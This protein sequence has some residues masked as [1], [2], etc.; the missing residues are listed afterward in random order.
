M[1]IFSQKKLKNFVAIDVINNKRSWGQSKS[2]DYKS[3]T[4]VNCDALVKELGA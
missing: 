4:S 2:W 1:H 3:S